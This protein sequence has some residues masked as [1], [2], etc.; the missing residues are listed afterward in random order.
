MTAW[1]WRQLEL[2]PTATFSSA[3]LERQLAADFTRLREGAVLRRLPHLAQSITA[4]GRLLAVDQID[5]DRFEAFDEDDPEYGPV[6]IDG[7]LVELWAVDL[8][9]LCAT[10][11]AANDLEGRASATGDDRVWV[12]GRYGARDWAIMLLCNCEADALALLTS[13]RSRVPVNAR[14][15]FV[16]TPSYEP[17]APMLRALG[18]DQINVGSLCHDLVF[19]PD[20]RAA[21]LP[22]V[23]TT[24]A[25]R[26]D[27]SG[28]VLVAGL[29]RATKAGREWTFGPKV[30]AVL[31]VLIRAKQEGVDAVDQKHLLREVSSTSRSLEELC[32]KSKVW[33]ELIV[34]ADAEGF[35]RLAG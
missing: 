20:P 10:I 29:R 31:Q 4:D 12:L 22:S 7:S 23:I 1:L 14:S 18:A 13:L 17:P 5:D 28:L 34:P 27:D 35:Y 11:A 2:N 24:V 30:G 19:E 8:P 33:R 21:L 32:G 26:D 15:L 6:T 3:E 16:V 25:A 9:S